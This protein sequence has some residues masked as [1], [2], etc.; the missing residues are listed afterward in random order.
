MFFEMWQKWQDLQLLDATPPWKEN[1][2]V[3][4]ELNLLKVFT[5]LK[6][7]L[8]VSSSYYLKFEFSSGIWDQV[9]CSSQTEE[10]LCRYGDFGVYSYLFLIQ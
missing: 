5:H 9:L 8:E 7:D 1:L 2:K 3:Q 10:M 6:Y 4:A